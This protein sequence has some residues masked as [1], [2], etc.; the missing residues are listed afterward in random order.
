MQRTE[1]SAGEW[2][3]LIRDPVLVVSIP[4]LEVRG[5][6]SGGRA[7]VVNSTGPVAPRDGSS[8][9]GLRS[10]LA[11][12]VADAEQYI[13][14]CARSGNPLPGTLSLWVKGDEQRFRV[15]GCLVR[16]GNGTEAALVALRLMNSEVSAKRFRLLNDKI[17][18][19]SQQISAKLRTERFLDDVRVALEQVT[20]GGRLDDTLSDLCC[21]VERYTPADT[22]ASVL[23]LNG[24]AGTLHHIGQS[25]LPRDYIEAIDGVSIGPNV[26]SCG[27][28]A[29]LNE[30]VVVTDIEQDPRWVG[31]KDLARVHGLRACWSTPI[32]ASD[33][34]VLGTFAFYCEE[35]RG[36][37][38]HESRIASIASRTAAIAIERSRERKRA[39]ALLERER[40]SRKEAEGTNRA[41]D[42][43]LAVVSHELRNPLS[44]ILGWARLLRDEEL[45]E[46]TRRRGVEAIER[47]AENQA[48][49]I[50]DVLDFSR[51][52]A[53]SLS[54]ETTPV[55]LAQLV[56]KVVDSLSPVAEADGIELIS[57]VPP[58][59]R[60]VVCDR[61]RIY[62]VLYNLVSNSIKFTP[63]GGRITVEFEQGPETAT[64]RV[65]DSGE[66]IDPDFLPFVFE[67]FRQADSSQTR[68][69]SGLGLGLAVVKS[70]VE[71]HGGSVEAHSSGKGEGS[72]FTVRLPVN[73]VHTEASPQPRPA[74]QPRVDLSGIHVL[75]VDDEPDARDVF[76]TVLERGGATVS[77]AASAS[78]A[79][80][81]LSSERPTVLL[82]DI[83]MP[84]IDG[85][86]LI[87]RVRER[88]DWAADIPAGALTAHV[89]DV[90]RDSALGRGYD[91]H[92]A[93]PVEPAE[94]LLAV[95]K[96]ARQDRRERTK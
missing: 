81:I 21:A 86:E 80:D 3:A 83:A 10:L 49:L 45:D 68:P 76:E 43:F 74:E 16:P 53:G 13:Q 87:E 23:L 34:S 62:Q 95:E 78:E 48:Q 59:D 52:S 79:L 40:R 92:L 82:S 14:L 35:T 12:D 30:E 6:N 77:S 41:K 94:L 32:P 57:K 63:R 67:R 44:S 1:P 7:L 29:F 36:P 73:P 54:L 26:G 50:T 20:T 39:K 27:T 25:G 66:G 69:H 18:E 88:T 64:L 89:R 33:G 37:T 5:G 91:L 75:V 42:E 9:V 11:S 70:L 71:L 56:E 60:P 72:T 17:D 65:T 84:G 22:V 2:G 24:R 15:D 46:E 58:F 85:L 8:P 28:A 4:G 96:L 55:Q 47:N 38:R 19:L 51:A 93:K 31:F 90:D 61:E